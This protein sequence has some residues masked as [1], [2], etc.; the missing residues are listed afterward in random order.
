MEQEN[1]QAMSNNSAAGERTFTQ[2]EV[3][4]I[5]GERLAKEKTKGDAAS[6][7][8]EQQ[9]AEREKQLAKRELLFDAKERI[10]KMGL[11][12]DLLEVLEVLDVSS[13]EALDKALNALQKTINEKTSTKGL[14]VYL[15]N[16]LNQG[17]PDAEWYDPVEKQ[18]REKM[19]LSN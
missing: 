7:E 5:I 10:D 16:R 11:P 3:N 18:L 6:A 15:P 14:R 9:L 19:G 4:R 17:D 2:E 12:A 13:P 1:N 8:R